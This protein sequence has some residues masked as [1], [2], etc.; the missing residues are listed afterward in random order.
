MKKKDWHFHIY[1]ESQI[2]GQSL[3]NIQYLGQ[4]KNA[5]YADQNLDAIIR[6]VAFKGIASI[7]YLLALHFQ[8][9]EALGKSQILAEVA[10]LAYINQ[11]LLLEL[12]QL[13][14]TA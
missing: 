11:R 2:R 9:A 10:R 8:V 14:G 6:T 13:K 4:F 12:A 7:S 5:E 1:D 3:R